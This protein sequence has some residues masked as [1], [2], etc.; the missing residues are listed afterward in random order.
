MPQELS[1]VTWEVNLEAVRKIAAEL[2]KSGRSDVP[3]SVDLQEG[4]DER[5]E[6]CIE[7]CPSVVRAQS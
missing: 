6:E 2:E 3:L 5:L 7:V 4:Y 1:A